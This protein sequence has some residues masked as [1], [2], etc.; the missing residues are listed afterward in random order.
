[1]SVEIRRVRA[2]DWRQVRE[3]R[4]E[5][6]RDEAAPIAFLDSVENATAQSDEFWQD[7]AANA[8]TGE[9]VAQFAAVDGSDWVG[10]AT[11][12]RRAAGETD[13]H[14]RT[15]VAARGD[16]VGVFVRAS[17]RGQGVVDALFETAGAWA[18]ALGDESLTLDVHVDNRRAQAAYRRAGF[19]PTGLRF[20]GSI[21]AELE[22]ARD[23][24][25]KTEG[26]S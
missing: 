14:G 16:I 7:R 6:L 24:V 26:A 1:M 25:E 13:H 17:H 12:L 15:L 4:L 2:E 10:S 21:G 8:A 23:L 20:T 11:V 9:A 22:M 3:S 18:R 5:A 19:V